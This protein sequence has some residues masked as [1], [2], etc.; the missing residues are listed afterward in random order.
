MSFTILIANKIVHVTFLLFVYFCDQ[1][2]A[3]K[4]HHSRRQCSVCQ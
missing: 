1:F 2:V 4:S 3:L